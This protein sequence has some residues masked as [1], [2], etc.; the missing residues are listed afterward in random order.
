MGTCKENLADYTT[1][2]H[3]PAHHKKERPIQLF[4]KDRSPSMLKGCVKTTNPESI[5][6][7]APR[8]AVTKNARAAFIHRLY[9]TQQHTRVRYNLLTTPRLL[10]PLLT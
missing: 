2:L 8:L 7:T 3:I 6:K 10:P 1:K 9:M 5:E 4:I